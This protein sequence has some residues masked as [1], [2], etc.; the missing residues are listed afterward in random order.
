MDHPSAAAAPISPTFTAPGPVLTDDRACVQCSYNL[1]GLPLNGNCPECGTPVETSLRGIL[2]QYA[3][4]DYLAT[5]HQGLSLVLNGIMLMIVL[6]V[7]GMVI[8]FASGAGG[9]PGTSATLIVAGLQLIPSVMMLLGYW[10]YTEPDPGFVGTELPTA[11][12][13]V[14]RITVII[15]AVTTAVSFLLQIAAPSLM[16]GGVNSSGAMAFGLLMMLVGLASLAAWTVQFFA[17]M[18]Y[19]RW[20]AVRVPDAQIIRRTQTYMW[21]LPLIAI[22]GA[23]VIIGPLIALV[24]YWN[25]HDR[26]RKHVRAI[27]ETGQPAALKGALG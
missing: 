15:Q 5:I 20:V 22:L 11:A 14:M 17:T 2:L 21:L 4:P 7:V 13:K 19:T 10:K 12:R 26:L 25:M 27:R 9:G 23:I 3:S 1:R 8:G 16:S 24:L 6:S 18:R